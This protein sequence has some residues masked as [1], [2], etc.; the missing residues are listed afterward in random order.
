MRR[1]GDAVGARGLRVRVDIGWLRG[2]VGIAAVVPV[3]VLLLG[4]LTYHEVYTGFATG[5]PVH[6]DGEGYYAYL[7]AYL[8]DSDPGFTHL[9]QDHI[10]PAY[11]NLPGMTPSW[12]GFSQQPS[13]AWLD[14]Y[15]VGEALLVLPFFAIGH[16]IAV[17][18]GVNASGYSGPETFASG[19]AALVYAVLALFALRAVLRRWFPGWAVAVTLIA[20]TF[21]TSLFHYVTYDSLFSHAF[22]FFA[23]AV[24][25]LTALRWYERPPS[26][27]RALAV[28]A[29]IGLVADIRLT[30]LVLV[31]ALPLLGIGSARAM[32]ARLALLWQQRLKVVA[33]AAVALLVFVPQSITWYVSTGHWVVRTYP[34]ESFDFLHPHLVESLLWLQPHGLLPYAPVMAFAFAGLAW[35]WVRR[36]DI[37][38]PVT[39]AFLPFWYLVSAWYDWSYADAF[40]NRAFVDVLPLLAIPLAYFLS[41]LR[42]QWLRAAVLSLGGA[43]VAATLMLMIAYWQ[44]RIGGAGADWSGYISVF[45]HPHLL[46]HTNLATWIVGR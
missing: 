9:V 33:A 11:A 38:I 1:G 12:F 25:I 39:V 29:A 26:W 23:V 8:I 42:W 44:Y 2:R 14:K 35:S 16:A 41:S 28:G 34:G 6:S 22:S 4:L 5:T 20:I 19:T 10:R 43:M 13:G 31:V 46:F 24:L 17:T 36:R 27:A 7:P 30:N 18:Q 45:R 3:A 37:A 21:G 40:G 32:R 15:G